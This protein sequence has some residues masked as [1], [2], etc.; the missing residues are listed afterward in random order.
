MTTSTTQDGTELGRLVAAGG[1]QLTTARAHGTTA[2]GTPIFT[3]NRYGN[4]SAIM[5]NF[6]A[7]DYQIW[8]TAGTEL[9]FRK[10]LNG[11][12]AE[13]GIE[14]YPQVKCVMNFGEK[15]SYPVR[16]TE[17]HRYEL[18]GGRYVGLLRHH[19]LRPD[20]NVH[21]ADLRVKPVMIHF[22]QPWHV[23]EMRSGLYRGHTDV[24]EDLIYPAQAELYALLPYEVRDLDIEA[25]WDS[26]AIMVSG[27]VSVDEPITHVFHVEL[28]DPQGRVRRELTRNIVAP[29][30]RFQE[31]FFVGYN[32][33][34]QGWSISVRDV[35]SGLDRAVTVKY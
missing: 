23:Y 34:P 4:G 2:S 11:L 35:A 30:G 10:E 29:E 25:Q 12:L 32:E 21:M 13:A 17:V 19:K 18:E 6:L 31:R 20:D 15:G 26:A 27:R 16:V 33:Q 8:R 5:L 28:S 7:R 22:D 14:S 9:A 3:F 1:I 24:V